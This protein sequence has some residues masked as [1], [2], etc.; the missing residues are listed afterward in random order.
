MI[1]MAHAKQQQQSKKRKNQQRTGKLPKAEKTQ[2]LLMPPDD[3]SSESPYFE[4]EDVDDDTGGM[5]LHKEDIRLISNALREYKPAEKEAHLHSVL[6]EEFE[7]I[8]V[9]DYGEPFP[10]AN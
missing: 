4:D 9:V 1:L 5:Y 8:L 2:I 7:E 6:I 3:G 10:D